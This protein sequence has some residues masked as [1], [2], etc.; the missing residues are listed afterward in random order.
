MASRD[1]ARTLVIGIG[2]PDRGDDGVGPLVIELLRERGDRDLAFLDHHGEGAALIEAWDGSAAVF[3]V[4]AVR[5]GAAP[6]AIHRIDACVRSVPVQIFHTSSH[7]FNVAE[8][9]ELARV[10]NRLPP[11]LIVYGVEGRRF[12]VGSGMSSEVA[13]ATDEVVERLFKE[14]DGSVREVSW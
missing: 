8:A 11:R 7:A 12:D 6:G 4:D 3:L 1:R 5:S 2:S 10:L 13:R 9:I 14:V